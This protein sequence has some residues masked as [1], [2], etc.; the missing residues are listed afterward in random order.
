M[1]FQR[2]SLWALALCGAPGM[3]ASAQSAEPVPPGA[4]AAVAGSASTLEA[5]PGGALPSP[6]VDEPSGTVADAEWT[7]DHRRYSSRDGSSGGLMLVEPGVAEPGS[8]RLQL[9]LE[10]VPRDD[11]L[12][13]GDDVS[14][15][16]SS[17][18]LGWTALRQLEIFAALDNRGTAGERERGSSLHAQGGQLGLK[19][20]DEVAPGFHLSGGLRASLRNDIGGQVPLLGAT[21]VGLRVAG[22][23]NFRRLPS[24]L[25][26]LARLNIDYLLDTSARLV[27]QVEARRYESLSDPLPRDDDDRRRRGLGD[28]L[29]EDAGGEAKA[30]FNGR[31]HIHPDAQKTDAQLNNRNL[32]LSNKAEVDTKPELE[33]YADDVKCAHG[34]TVAQMEDR[35]LYYLQ[36]RGIGKQQAQA[37]L[38][39]GFINELLEEMPDQAICNWLRPQIRQ[40]F[41]AAFQHND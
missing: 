1:S 39:F 36:S 29:Q 3:N 28:M 2:L 30:V 37:M 20:S 4:A 11:F 9:L 15:S 16:R 23:A 7:F 12:R 26:L 40:R 13:E 38:T 31:I 21:T 5:V 25:P 41:N 33:I 27:E 6:E 35:A 34:A 14:Q 32:L 18:T 19:L 24:R 8:L 10:T 22:S 17:L